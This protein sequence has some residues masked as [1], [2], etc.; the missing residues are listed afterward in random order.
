MPEPRDETSGQV[1]ARL[2][3]TQGILSETE[4]ILK[5]ETTAEH[6]TQWPNVYRLESAT[7]HAQELLALANP[8]INQVAA[9]DEVVTSARQARDAIRA[10]VDSGGGDLIGSADRLLNA[11]AQIKPQLPPEDAMTAA[12]AVE[13]LN[14]I[15]RELDSR[16]AAL[17]VASEGLERA[18]EG[19]ETRE[20]TLTK[21]LDDLTNVAAEV[22]FQKQA[23]GRLPVSSSLEPAIE[24]A[25]ASVTGTFP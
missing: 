24:I 4:R 5:E 21:F 6:R 20:S 14:E 1:A 10:A 13:R 12:S 16:K 17:E 11:T 25:T 7:K 8:G 9:A 3:E 22:E 2:S 19:F 15:Q 18:Q 23:E